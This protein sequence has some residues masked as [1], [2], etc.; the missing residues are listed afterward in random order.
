MILN[1][2]GQACARHSDELRQRRAR[3]GQARVGELAEDVVGF[4]KED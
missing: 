3:G 4:V 2:L 1:V